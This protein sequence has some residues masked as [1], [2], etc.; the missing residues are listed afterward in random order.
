[1]GWN[2]VIDTCDFVRYPATGAV[3]FKDWRNNESI[4]DFVNR[5]NLDD[6]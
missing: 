2:S 6:V 5:W 4:A 1:M 3:A